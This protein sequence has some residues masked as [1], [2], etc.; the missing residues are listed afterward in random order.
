MTLIPQGVEPA[1]DDFCSR[2]TVP[3]LSDFT[4]YFLSACKCYSSVFIILDALDE[5]SQDTLDVVS[6]VICQLKECN[7][8][9]FATARPHLENSLQAQFNEPPVLQVEAHDDDVRNYLSAKLNK[10]WRY[11]GNFK[12]RIIDAVAG[13]AKG[14]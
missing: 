14:K 4:K 13:G 11:A 6:S 8:R 1:Y 9:V 2:S 3:S 10:G 5:C 12:E 7:I